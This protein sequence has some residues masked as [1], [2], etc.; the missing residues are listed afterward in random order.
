MVAVRIS[1]PFAVTGQSAWWTFTRDVGF[2]SKVTGRGKNSAG[3]VTLHNSK[4]QSMTYTKDSIVFAELSTHPRF[5]DITGQT[6]NQLAVLGFAGRSNKRSWWFAE[7]ECGNIVKVEGGGLKDGKGKSCGCRRVTV[8]R[9]RSVTHG[10]TVGRK[11]TPAYGAFHSARERCNNSQTAQYPNYGGRGI[12]F[13][14]DSFEEFF[15]EVGDRPEDG[16]YSLDRIDVNGHYEKGNLRWA[17]AKEQG[18]NTRTNRL[19]TIDGVTRCLAEWAEVADS[20][21]GRIAG[22]LDRYG[23]CNWCAVFL[24]ERG[25]CQHKK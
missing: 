17:T 18:R 11:E 6:F 20:N 8:T 25:Q 4:E 16:N 5:V 12:E 15:A 7:C 13:R 21:P 24:P 9:E 14:F 23:F 22:R 10:A 19:I 2:K 3:H 1:F